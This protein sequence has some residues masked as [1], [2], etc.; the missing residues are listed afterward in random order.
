MTSLANFEDIPVIMSLGY[1][2]FKENLCDE[3][4][5]P[6]SFDKAMVEIAESINQQLTFVK[7]V[8]DTITGVLATKVYSAWF[9]EKPCLH[10]L[11]FYI[12]PEYRSFKE[13]K[14]FIDFIKQYAI[15]NKVPFVID[16]FAQKDVKKKQ[17]L[18][19][20]FGFKDCGSVMAFLEPSLGD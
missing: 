12:K 2:S 8:D 7:R 1:A 10:S 20:Y 4:D 13:T 3:F 14:L 11:L 9:S 15:L 6:I 17:Q 18:F 19:K 5:L 16:F